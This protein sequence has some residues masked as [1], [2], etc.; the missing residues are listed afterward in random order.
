MGIRRGDQPDRLAR[1]LE[2][3]APTSHDPAIRGMLQAAQALGPVEPLSESKRSQTLAAALRELRRPAPSEATDGAG[4]RDG[5]D[6]IAPHTAQ[7]TT[8]DDMVIVLADVEPIDEDRA[9]RAAAHAA[10][11]IARV[12]AKD[13]T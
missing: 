8:T 3:T 9:A 1:H 6:V 12:A 2:G 7:V 5:D 11:L 10:E 4:T 13:R